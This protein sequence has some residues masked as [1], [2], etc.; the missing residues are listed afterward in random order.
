M[1]IAGYPILSYTILS[2]FI[3]TARSSTI[4][5]YNKLYSCAYT[6]CKKRMQYV[7]TSSKREIWHI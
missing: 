2:R 3:L 1:G 5:E 7:N 4:L 6:I